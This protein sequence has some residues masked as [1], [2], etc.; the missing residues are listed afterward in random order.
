MQYGI[1]RIFSPFRYYCAQNIA[2]GWEEMDQGNGNYNGPILPLGLR[3]NT[4]SAS[5]IA[6]RVARWR[7]AK[8]G[9]VVAWRQQGWFVNMYEIQAVDKEAG[10]ISWA[11][12]DGMP[13][14]GWQGGRGWQLNGTTGSI[15]PNPPSSKMC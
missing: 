13:V 5:T 10:T 6:Q 12:A 11:D 7:D 8:R 2:G 4:S 3:F 15:D 9:I 14:G 1:C